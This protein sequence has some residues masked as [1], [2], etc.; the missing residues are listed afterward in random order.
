VQFLP[1]I[2]VIFIMYM[3]MWRPQQKKMREHKA[4]IAAVKR[5]DRVV[6]AGGIIGV[7]SKVVDESE[8]QL[9]VAEASGC[10]SCAAA[11]TT[12]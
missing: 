10:A 12:C 7:V 6:A 9:E 3:L 11:S 5:G 4:M 1:I 2:L 8:V